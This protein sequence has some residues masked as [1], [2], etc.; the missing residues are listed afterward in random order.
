[1]CR[2]FRSYFARGPWTQLETLSQTLVIGLRLP[3]WPVPTHPQ[4][5]T[6]SAD[7]AWNPLAVVME[8]LATAFFSVVGLLTDTQ[9]TCS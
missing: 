9:N 4:L 5:A 3:W 2:Y 8:W 1:M 7:Y 6:P